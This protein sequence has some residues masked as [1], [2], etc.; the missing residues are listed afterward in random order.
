MVF[1]VSFV[2]LHLAFNGSLAPCTLNFCAALPQT[3][4]NGAGHSKEYPARQEA[5]AHWN[6]VSSTLRMRR[7]IGNVILSG[8]LIMLSAGNKIKAHA[9]TH[10]IELQ[11]KPFPKSAYSRK[12]FFVCFWDMTED[13]ARNLLRWGALISM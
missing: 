9:A 3:D 8:R 6:R 5:Y 7:A 13:R 1:A 12:I 11:L 4:D 2:R 10:F